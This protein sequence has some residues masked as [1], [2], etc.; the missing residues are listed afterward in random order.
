MAFE[1]AAADVDAE[2]HAVRTMRRR[3]VDC[4]DIDVDQDVGVLTF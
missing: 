3:A 2:R 1:I 4:I